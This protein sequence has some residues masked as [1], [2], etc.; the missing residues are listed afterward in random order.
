MKTSVRLAILFSLLLTL[1]PVT[2]LAGNVHLSTTDGP[3]MRGLNFASRK[4]TEEAAAEFKKCKDLTPATAQQLITI[5]KTYLDVGDTSSCLSLITYALS[6]ERVKRDKEQTATLLDLRG[7]AFENLVKLDDATTA[8]KMAAA[9]DPSSSR[10][11]LPKAGKQLMK[12]KRYTEALPLLEK[13]IKAGDMNGFLYQDI[14]HCYLELNAPAKAIAPLTAS[15]NSF[16]AFRKNSEAYLPGLVQSYKYLINAYERTSNTK[17]ARFWQKR[18]DTLVG[19]LNTDMF[20]G[21]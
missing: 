14:G 1:G 10:F 15:V 7:T 9:A 18:M 13:G 3:L 8:Y 20:G 5:A 21:R 19:T 2:A 4:Y 17:E 11:Y 6:Q 12:N 16:E